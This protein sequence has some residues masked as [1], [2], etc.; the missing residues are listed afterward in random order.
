[1]AKHLDSFLFPESDELLNKKITD[2]SSDQEP[3][4]FRR[5]WIMLIILTMLTAENLTQ[6]LFYSAIDNIVE[7]HYKVSSLLAQCL[8]LNN[9]AIILFFGLP[10]VGIV[11]KTD[12][13][14]SCLISGFLSLIALWIKFFGANSGGFYLT[15]C[16][17]IL[18]SLGTCFVLSLPAQLASTW[19]GIFE[20][21]LA[22][23]IAASGLSFGM[24]AAYLFSVRFVPNSSDNKAIEYGLQQSIL[25]QAIICA[26]TVLATIFIFEKKPPVPPSRSQAA[27][28]RTQLGHRVTFRESV[29]LLLGNRSYNY[30][31]LA[32]G[33]TSGVLYSFFSLL[34]EIVLSKFH[35]KE[36]LMGWMGFLGAMIGIPGMALA[37]FWLDKTKTYKKSFVVCSGLLAL[38]ML[39]FTLAIKFTASSWVV[40]ILI[41]LF[42]F[43]TSALTT[44]GFVLGGELTYP[45]PEIFS[46]GMLLMAGQF[47][48][49]ILLGVSSYTIS[50]ISVEF[51]NWLLTAACF[52]AFCF[53]PFV[54]AEFRRLAKEVTEY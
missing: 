40:F 25:I 54:K 51:V 10:S 12:L 8:S 32:F 21:S 28:G 3:K 16:G 37:G 5:R 35:G 43:L 46:T 48:G 49:V 45:V 41:G 9:L 42:G 33:I 19:F 27:V 4:L 2:D 38:I 26:I 15:V 14:V 13:K 31:S 29:K 18:A 1:M 24:G 36:D 34:N 39:A 30:V 53:T 6:W 44:M 20:R 22:T 7:H 23:S 47:F 11:N 50:A 52:I 17:Q